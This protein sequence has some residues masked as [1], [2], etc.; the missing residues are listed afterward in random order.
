MSFCDCKPIIKL[1]EDGYRLRKNLQILFFVYLAVIMGKII[2]TDYDA[3][4]SNILC[5]FMAILAFLQA[6]FIYCAILIFF[7][8]ANLFYSGIFLGLRIQN[9][10]H[11]L[12]DH[13]TMNDGLYWFAVIFTILSIVFFCFLIYYSFQAFKTFKYLYITYG[14][15]KFNKI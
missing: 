12:P 13:F 4:L 8:C 6:N 14:Y 10:V 15:S 9:R 11:D 1:N 5:A 2:I 3:I 7:A